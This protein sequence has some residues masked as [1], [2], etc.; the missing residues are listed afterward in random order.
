M[1]K[2]K[3]KG[4]VQQLKDENRRLKDELRYETHRR[5]LALRKCEFHEEKAK[6]AATKLT[7]ELAIHWLTLSHAGG[8]IELPITELK[9]AMEGKKVIMVRRSERPGYIKFTVN[10]AEALGE[11]EALAEKEK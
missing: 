1:K 3:G 2:T 10:L 5:T 8:S 7:N 6:Q 4:L 11:M 9:A